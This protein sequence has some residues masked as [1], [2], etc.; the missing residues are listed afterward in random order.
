MDPTFLQSLQKRGVE[1]AG[2]LVSLA[3]IPHPIAALYPACTGFSAFDQALL[4]LPPDWHV[5]LGKE[6]SV[7]DLLGEYSTGRVF[8]L[9]LF[10]GLFVAAAD[11]I[12]RVNPETREA[13]EHSADAEEW[14]MKILEAPNFETGW[15][16][17][18]NWQRDNRLL[19]SY[20]RLLPRQP[21]VLGGE[22]DVGNLVPRDLKEALSLYARLS[23]RVEALEDGEA[24]AI[25][26]W[27]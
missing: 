26:G 25:S 11:R 17:A 24:V 14:A 1:L 7:A 10:G 23:A 20:E 8:A 16:L 9:D 2:A 13:E 4:V 15:E 3:S 22:Y 6:Q 5:R 18:M 27:L 19:H 12:L 21:F